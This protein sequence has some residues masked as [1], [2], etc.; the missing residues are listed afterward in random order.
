MRN[1]RLNPMSARVEP[2]ID[3]IFRVFEE[4]A[5]IVRNR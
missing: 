4:N 1:V 2:S 3:E 5:C